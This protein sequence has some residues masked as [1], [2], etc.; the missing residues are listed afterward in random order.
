MSER[1][2]PEAALIYIMVIMSAADRRMSDRELET[3]GRLVRTLPVFR[4]FSS[5]K[6]VATAQGCAALLAEA[7]G[8][9][10]VLRRVREA[11]S[12]KLK[13]TAYALA[14]E[15]AAADGRAGQVELRLLELIRE[16]LPVSA[17]I[18]QAIEQSARVRYRS[19]S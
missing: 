11:L 5:E 19:L 13:E 16:R 10:G 18:A 6:L 9:E 17:S 4:G 7:D 12:D 3:I 1:L 2:S 8:L 15:V 14:V